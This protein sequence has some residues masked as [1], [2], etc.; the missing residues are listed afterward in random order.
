MCAYTHAHWRGSLFIVWPFPYPDQNLSIGNIYEVRCYS[1]LKKA[2]EKTEREGRRERERER[3][4]AH[5]QFLHADCSPSSPIILAS[6]PTLSLSSSL[7]AHRSHSSV[8]SGRTLQG[9][10]GA[11]PPWNRGCWTKLIFLLLPLFSDAFSSL[12][13]PLPFRCLPTV[14]EGTQG[15]T[16]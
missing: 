10:K 2:M 6:F 4:G 9:K 7:R 16:K 8:L 13:S 5:V 11:S 3:R 12:A 15:Q 1:K 14:S